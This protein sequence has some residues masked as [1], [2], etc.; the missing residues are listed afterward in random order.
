MM[1]FAAN[2]LKFEGCRIRFTHN[3]WKHSRRLQ[4]LRQKNDWFE[5]APIFTNLKLIDNFEKGV[6]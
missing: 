6:K 1:R 3:S 4:V 2:H 5:V